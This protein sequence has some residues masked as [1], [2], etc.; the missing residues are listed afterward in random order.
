MIFGAIF[1]SLDIW[2]I[3]LWNCD[4]GADTLQKPTI[5]LWSY[6]FNSKL[7]RNWWV[8]SWN[9]TV[10][11]FSTPYHTKQRSKLQWALKKKGMYIYTL[12]HRS[13]RPKKIILNKKT[14]YSAS[15]C[16]KS[17]GLAIKSSRQNIKNIISNSTSKNISIFHFV[18]CTITFIHDVQIY[19]FQLYIN[20]HPTMLYS[21]MF[22]GADIRNPSSTHKLDPHF[23]NPRSENVWLLINMPCTFGHYLE[24]ITP[25]RY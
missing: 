22:L 13:W 23:E 24:Q 19:Y 4:N 5:F 25:Y 20:H 1:S 18:V 21:S 6:I 3:K 2:G 11:H 8:S 10:Q 17:S 14:D 9:Y 15:T 16:T 12:Q 7:T